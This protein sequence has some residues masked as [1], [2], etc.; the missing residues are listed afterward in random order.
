MAAVR[1][2]CDNLIE[3]VVGILLLAIVTMTI[4]QVFSRYV[5]NAPSSWSDEVAQLLLVW[6]AFLG[7]AVGVKR[8]SHIQIDLVGG[9]LPAPVRR[10]TALL[11]NALMLVVAVSMA[12]YGWQFYVAT[13][14]DTSTSLGF[15]RNLFYLPIPISGL[16]MIVLLVPATWRSVRDPR[17]KN[18]RASGDRA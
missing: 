6:A 2:V 8:N 4:W 12:V 7:A 15:P 10:Y 3:W 9:R 18:G 17:P 16:L 1:W 11:V 5:L 14:N 13:G